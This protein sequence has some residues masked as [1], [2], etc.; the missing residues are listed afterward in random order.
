M[1]SQILTEFRM[2]HY[3]I[4]LHSGTKFELDKSKFAQV[5]QFRANIQKNSKFRKIRTLKSILAKFN[6]I[7]P[8]ICYI[9][10]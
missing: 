1:P 3:L 10:L 5:R 2:K 8:S 9:C 7:G 6:T 4:L